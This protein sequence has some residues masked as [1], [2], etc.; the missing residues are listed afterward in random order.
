MDYESTDYE[1]QPFQFLKGT[2]MWKNL[3]VL[4]IVFLVS[5]TAV[6]QRGEYAGPAG[7]TWGMSPDS[8]KELLKNRFTFEEKLYFENGLT[9]EHVYSG[10]FAGFGTETIATEFYEN[11]LFGFVV[12]LED[13]TIYPILKRWQEVVDKMTER[14]GEPDTLS[15]S[16]EEADPGENASILYKQN[17]ILR[18]QRGELK[19][20]AEWEFDNDVNVSVVIQLGKK[21]ELGLRK[22]NVSWLF[23]YMKIAD[24]WKQAV[25]S[26]RPKDF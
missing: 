17:Q 8:V 16:R 6:A 22:M 15:L 13:E 4:I 20:F 10:T 12:I 25:E 24:E 1:S 19:P 5:S 2:A 7:L 18:I 21:D 14:Y 26:S 23:L 11:R 9:L 3:I